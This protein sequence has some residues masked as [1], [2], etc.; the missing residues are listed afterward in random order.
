M[1][2]SEQQKMKVRA[3]K[4]IKRVNLCITGDRLMVRQGGGFVGFFEF[5]E[6]KGFMNPN[7]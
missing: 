7:I 6:K 5:L 4:S 1:L 3:Q 2:A